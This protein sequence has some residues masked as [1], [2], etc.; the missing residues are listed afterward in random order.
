[1]ASRGT[2]LRSKPGDAP[3]VALRQRTGAGMTR[4]IFDSSHCA[5]G[6]RF[7]WRL[8]CRPAVFATGLYIDAI[9]IIPEF[10]HFLNILG[11]QKHWHGG[12]FCCSG[13]RPSLQTEVWKRQV[14]VIEVVVSGP[15][16]CPASQK[17]A[18]LR[19]NSNPRPWLAIIAG[20]V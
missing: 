14:T 20:R 15:F 11:I 13:S 6:G 10:I 16:R 17:K 9:C 12:L 1:M 5:L 2:R 4:C 3:G 19:C 18:A 8:V 7:L